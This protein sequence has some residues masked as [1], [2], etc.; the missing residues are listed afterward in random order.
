MHDALLLKQPDD[1]KYCEE[2]V[3][4]LSGQADW[5]LLRDA[6]RQQRP[7]VH[8]I[9]NDHAADISKIICK[10]GNGAHEENK[11]DS[12]LDFH[13]YLEKIINPL[14]RNGNINDG[15]RPGTF[16]DRKIRWSDRPSTKNITDDGTT[17]MLSV[18]PTCYPH[19]QN[20]IHRNPV[21]ALKLMLT[22]LQK[23]NDPYAFFA[24]GMGV[25]V[26]PL[27]RSGHVFIGKREHT[28]DYSNFLCFVSG[29]ATFSPNIKEI[30]FHRDVNRE[31]QEEIH[32]HGAIKWEKLRCAGLSGHPITGEVDIV[33]VLQTDLSDDYFITGHWPE[34]ACWYAIRSKKEAK[35]LLEDGRIGGVED[36][37]SVMF[38]SRLGLEYLISNHWSS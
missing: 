24:R 25:V 38:S 6:L 11:Y 4:A 28:A 20:D 7:F 26:V 21:D 36:E 8:W 37:F 30:N 29:W 15:S 14:I 9:N 27:T 5:Q 22:G 17:L 12:A 35:R 13:T 23:Y 33:F 32:F 18:G 34:H 3:D 16:D 1:F 31:L 2:L 10:E 19:C